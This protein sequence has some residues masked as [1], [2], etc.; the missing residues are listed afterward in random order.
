MTAERHP[1]LQGFLFG[2][3]PFAFGYFVLGPEKDRHEGLVLGLVLIPVVTL[4]IAG[5]T[6]LGRRL[7]R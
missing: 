7:R 2:S 4:L 6:W 1:L 5:A 3:L